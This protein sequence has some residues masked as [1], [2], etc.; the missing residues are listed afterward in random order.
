MGAAVEKAAREAA[1]CEHRYWCECGHTLLLFTGS[2]QSEG[3]GP[4]CGR[5]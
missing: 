5:L 1:S 4:S 3:G 2:L